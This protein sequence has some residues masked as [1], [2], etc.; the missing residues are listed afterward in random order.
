MRKVREFVE[1]L[2]PER[3]YPEFGAE[4]S[5]AGS[6]L[7][8]HFKSIENPGMIKL[9]TDITKKNR[10]RNRKRKRSNDRLG[11]SIMEYKCR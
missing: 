5:S 8:T 9:G 2:E 10:N 3:K 6:I 7:G 11:S 4:P 1:I